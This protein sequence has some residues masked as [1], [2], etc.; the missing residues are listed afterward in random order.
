MGITLDSIKQKLLGNKFGNLTVVEYAGRSDYGYNLWRCKCDCG[1]M[2]TGDTKQVSSSLA[3]CTECKRKRYRENNH[4]RTDLVGRKSNALTVIQ[5]AGVS[6]Y[7]Q[8]EWLCKCD[9]GNEIVV[10]TANITQGIS[11]SCGC[12]SA[13]NRSAAS[14][15]HGLHKHPLY[16]VWAA[17]KDRCYN[18]NN[19]HYRDY[20]GRGINVTEMWLADFTV[21]YSWA[22]V[23]GY[24]KG[25]TLER[26]DNHGDYEPGNC[27]WATRHEQSQNT[28][29][30]RISPEDVE[31][32]RQDPRTNKA[33]ASDYG[34]NE[35]TISR[36]KAKRTWYNVA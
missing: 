36:I 30:T 2:V 11:K 17:M 31:T 6:K 10:K 29:R 32:I 5:F 4:Y 26:V 8:L 3:A 16:A 25:L 22:M 12:L 15:K 9:C 33:I 34:V 19:E 1:I 7:G 18:P 23:N 14:T 21:F 27:R 13:Q 28:R 24:Q 20:G 35:S